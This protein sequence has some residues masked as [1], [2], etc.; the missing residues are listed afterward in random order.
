[1]KLFKRVAGA[2]AVVAGVALGSGAQAAVIWTF[3]ESGG[4]VVS[5]HSGSLDI[6]G[7][8]VFGSGFS[9][10]SMISGRAAVL[11]GGLNTDVYSGLVGPA[12]FGT[13]VTKTIGAGSGS[14]FGIVGDVGILVVDA[15]YASGAAISGALNFA[16]ESFASLGM[17]QGTFVFS[18]PNDTVTVQIGPTPAAVPLPAGG[19]LLASALAALGLRRRRQR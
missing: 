11:S 12:S 9:E 7:L 18:L 4:D 14:V 15:G 6:A 5:S 10:T 8:S 3:E 16:G 19:L 1:M 2:A 17:T 13:A